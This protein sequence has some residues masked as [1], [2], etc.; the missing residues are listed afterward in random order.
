M[1]DTLSAL[2][3]TPLPDFTNAR[4]TLRAAA[5]TS[6]NVTDPRNPE[7]LIALEAC[8][9]KGSNYYA[10]DRNPP[11]FHRAP[12]AIDQLFLRRSVV[13]KL[14]KIN[15]VLAADG[16]SLHVHDG[17]RPLAVQAYFHDVWVPRE[18]TRRRPD[19]TPVEILAEADRYWSRP[20]DDP[21]RPSPHLTGGAVDLTLAWADSGQPLFMG[22]LFDDPAPISR[23]DFYETADERGFSFSAEEARANRRLLFWLMVGEGFANYPEE[24]WHFS[25]GDQ[26]WARLTG[27]PAAIYGG[28]AP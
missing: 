2:R 17:W 21:A 26:M 23:T 16:L 11:Y 10:S 6:I 1:F 4:Q 27:A 19:L 22:G 3:E 13:G 8:G 18:L 14:V 28:A 7:P 9:V 20:S 12:G 5:V 24:W 25:W 15:E